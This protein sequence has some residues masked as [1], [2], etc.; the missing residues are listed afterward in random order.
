MAAK[1]LYMDAM[2][3]PSFAGPFAYTQQV[4][5]KTFLGQS[6]LAPVENVIAALAAAEG[7]AASVPQQKIIKQQIQPQPAPQDKAAM[8]AQMCAPKACAPNDSKCA[9]QQVACKAKCMSV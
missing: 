1:Q 3:N 6:P 5:M 7:G 8:C 4:P 2:Q 9:G